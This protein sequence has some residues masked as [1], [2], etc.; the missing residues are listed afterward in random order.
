MVASVRCACTDRDRCL[1]YALQSIDKTTLSYAAVFGLV[2]L[3]NR[4]SVR[5]SLLT[6]DATERTDPSRRNTILLAW[7]TLLSGLHG[8]RMACVLLGT[9]ASSCEVTRHFG[10]MNSVQQDE[11]IH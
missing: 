6:A 11:V 10:T 8:S 4:R 1:T 9:E 7:L 5:N 3:R 2:G